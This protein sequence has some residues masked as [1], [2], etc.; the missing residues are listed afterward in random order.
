MA[1]R[2]WILLAAFSILGLWWYVQSNPLD[3]T[4]LPT[5]PAAA[6]T[7]SRLP[8]AAN[9]TLRLIRL[10][11][12]FPYEEDGAVFANRER[13]LPGHRHGY[14]HEYTVRIPGEDD[15][16]PRRL[17]VGDGGEVFYTSDHYASFQRVVDADVRR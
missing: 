12:P 15:R 14:W 1:A 8:S 5:D 4:A 13:L 9:E 7:V 2:F 10:G 6:T 3:Q 16:G 17:V 11:G